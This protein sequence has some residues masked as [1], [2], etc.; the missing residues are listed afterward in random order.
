MNHNKS[1]AN[2]NPTPIAAP[3][4]RGTR[5]SDE[6]ELRDAGGLLVVEVPVGGDRDGVVLFDDGVRELGGGGIFGASLSGGGGDNVPPEELV[7][8]GITGGEFTG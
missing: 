5:G 6:E 3:T 7:G 8:G 2:N 1:K 4:R